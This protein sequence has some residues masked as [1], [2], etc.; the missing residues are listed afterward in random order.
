MFEWNMQDEKLFWLVDEENSRYCLGTI[1]QNCRARKAILCMKCT[2]IN[3][4]SY[5]L[6]LVFKLHSYLEFFL[7]KN[8]S[9]LALFRIAENVV[10][11][12]RGENEVD[13][14][15]HYVMYSKAFD[16]DIF[17][18]DMIFL[19]PTLE[20]TNKDVNDIFYVIVTRKN[21]SV[22]EGG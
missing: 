6:E 18:V 15:N 7:G 17:N 2:N 11:V 13:T 8:I 19:S 22:I 5:T 1:S 14:Y 21:K 20:S 4:N 9:P 3:G 12:Y 10:K 16:K